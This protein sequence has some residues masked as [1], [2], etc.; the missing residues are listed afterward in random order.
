MPQAAP[1]TSMIG[2]AALSWG[3]RREPDLKGGSSCIWTCMHGIE[4]R[5]L[6]PELSWGIWAGCRHDDGADSG[7]KGIPAAVL[8]VARCGGAMR[9]DEAGC[10]CCVC[11]CG[12]GGGGGGGG[13]EEVGRGRRLHVGGRRRCGCGGT[14]A[15]CLQGGAGGGAVCGCRGGWSWLRRR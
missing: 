10:R 1:N 5:S 3:Q 13:E 7:E 2:D 12:G 14:G 11:V 15:A 6:R 8:C 9:E 4:A